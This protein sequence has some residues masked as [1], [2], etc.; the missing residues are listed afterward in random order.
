MMSHWESA[1]PALRV[2]F[3]EGLMRSPART[4]VLLAAVEAGTVKAVE[5]PADRREQLRIHP[6]P[7]IRDLASKLFE[8][9]SADRLKVVAEYE[10]ALDSGD[11]ERGLA[12]FRKTCA[13][14][15]KFG[16]EGALVGPQLVSVKNKSPRDLLLAILDPNREA[17]PQ[18]MNYTVA[19]DDGRLFTGIL[20]SETD[21]SVTLRKA[22]GKED[23]I[24]REQIELMRSTGQSLMPVGLEKDLT[25]QD[26]ADVIAWIKAL[27]G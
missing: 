6:D 5:L 10:P 17:L 20:V 27:E 15:H 21:S 8:A 16:K 3:L 2:E 13:Q 18:Y 14:C 25:P 26:I 11:A 7:A 23:V 22:E 1:A 12:V 19:T 4:K 9:A 24:P